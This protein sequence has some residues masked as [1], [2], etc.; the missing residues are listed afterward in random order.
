MCFFFNFFVPSVKSFIKNVMSQIYFLFRDA[1]VFWFCFRRLKRSFLVSWPNKASSTEGRLVPTQRRH[2][3]LPTQL[4]G[5]SLPT[6]SDIIACWNI[7]DSVLNW[8]P[9]SILEIGLFRRLLFKSRSY[10]VENV[11][12]FWCNS[13]PRARVI[14]AALLWSVFSGNCIVSLFSVAAQRG[15]C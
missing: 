9:T 4:A 11:R 15:L 10:P 13:Q 6:A 14:Q 7:T 8:Q 5:A 12:T 3:P 2:R 1:T